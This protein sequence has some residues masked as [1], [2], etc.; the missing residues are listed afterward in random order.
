MVNLYD[1]R[2]NMLGSSG[3]GIGKHTGAIQD[4]MDAYF[5]NRIENGIDGLYRS[6]NATNIYGPARLNTISKVFIDFFSGDSIHTTFRL[7]YK[8]NKFDIYNYDIKSVDP[9]KNGVEPVG[10]GGSLYNVDSG[11][12]LSNIIQFTTPPPIGANNVKILYNIMSKYGCRL[13]SSAFLVE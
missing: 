7:T 6:F 9:Y 4:N 8:I 2:L 12:N 5:A 11:T 13:G 3:T 10:L 1:F